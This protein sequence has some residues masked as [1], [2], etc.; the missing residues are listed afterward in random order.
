[1]APELAAMYVVGWVPSGTVTGLQILWHRKKVKSAPYRQLQRNLQKV[2]LL[3]RESTAQIEPFRKGKE[4]QDLQNYEK[5]LLLMGV[6]FLLLSWLGL[7]F[8]LIVL[9]SVHFIAISRHER[10]IFASELTSQDLAAPEVQ[11][12]LREFT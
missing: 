2:D 5:N 7:I 9:F 6:F 3:W 10:K 4:L 12:L 11:D 1:M 8:N